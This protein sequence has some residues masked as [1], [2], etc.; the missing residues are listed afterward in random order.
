VTDVNRGAA[1]LPSRARSLSLLG[2]T[3]TSTGTGT[4]TTRSSISA[5]QGVVQASTA[6]R[7]TS[8]RTTVAVMAAREVRNH[9]A[10]PQPVRD[11]RRPRRRPFTP[12]ASFQCCRMGAAAG[13]SQGWGH[14]R[15]EAGSRGS[16]VEVVVARVVVA[17]VRLCGG[18]GLGLGVGLVA[19]ALAASHLGGGESQRRSGLLDVQFEG[20]A[21]VA[22]LVRELV[23]LELADDDHAVTLLM[24]LGEVL[25]VLPPQRAAQERRITVDPLL[26]VLVEVAVVAGDGERRDRDLL[27]G[28]PQLG[29]G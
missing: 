6:A 11:S 10:V 9:Q 18:G 7:I 27:L 29:I 3:V 25:A 14:R 5:C 15:P 19:V 20:D 26:G 13:A 23:L 4:Y 22:L 1:P 16:E 2:S 28:V 24:R 21:L 8:T 17:G 12:G